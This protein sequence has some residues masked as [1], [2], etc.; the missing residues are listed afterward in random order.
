M[1]GSKKV[2]A[3]LRTVRFV[4]AVAMLAAVVAGAFGYGDVVKLAGAT[5]GATAALTLKALHVVA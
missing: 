4:A 5:I 2:V 3:T 1:S